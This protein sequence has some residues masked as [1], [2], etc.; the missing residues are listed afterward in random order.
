MTDPN[1]EGRLNGA[2]AALKLCKEL[3]PPRDWPEY[4]RLVLKNHEAFECEQRAECVA[5]L[6]GGAS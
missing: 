5:R 3:I 1:Y 6:K 4:A 2:I